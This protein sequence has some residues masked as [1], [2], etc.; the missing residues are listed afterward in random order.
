MTTLEKITCFSNKISEEMK[1]T[2]CLLNNTAISQDFKTNA[3][4]GTIGSINCIFLY[5]DKTIYGGCHSLEFTLY[6]DKIAFTCF[7]D[8]NQEEEKI[9]LDEAICYINESKLNSR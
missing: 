9:T 8:N 7:F 1:N 5:C 3:F 6:P 2:A 4:E